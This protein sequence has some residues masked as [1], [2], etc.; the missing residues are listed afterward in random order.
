MPDVP[1]SRPKKVVVQMIM[2]GSQQICGRFINFA[3]R[4]IEGKLQDSFDVDLVKLLALALH[5]SV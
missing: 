2:Q 5:Y 3:F 1:C 4:K